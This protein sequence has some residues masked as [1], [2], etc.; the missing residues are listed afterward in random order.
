MPFHVPRLPADARPPIGW[1]PAPFS[2]AHLKAIAAFLLVPYVL[3]G[4]LLPR[5]FSPFRLPEG[6]ASPSW[7]LARPLPLLVVLAAGNAY[8]GQ[9]V[10]RRKFMFMDRYGGYE[11]FWKLMASGLLLVN[12]GVG[13]PPPKPSTTLFSFAPSPNFLFYL[14]FIVGLQ[15]AFGDSIPLLQ[16]FGCKWSI[17]SR[18]PSCT[19]A[20]RIVAVLLVGGVGGAVALVATRLLDAPRV[21]LEILA[22]V[23]GLAFAAIAAFVYTRR[24]MHYSFHLHHY[25]CVLLLLPLTGSWDYSEAD[26]AKASSLAAAFLDGLLLGIYVDGVTVWG[27][28]PLLVPRTLRDIPNVGETDLATLTWLHLT[29]IV[30]SPVKWMQ[31]LRRLEPIYEAVIR[32]LGKLPRPS[33]FEFGILPAMH[34]DTQYADVARRMRMDANLLA[35]YMEIDTDRMKIACGV[36]AGV[37]KK[38]LGP[39]RLMARVRGSPADRPFA[40]DVTLSVCTAYMDTLFRFLMF[41]GRE[42]RQLARLHLRWGS[43]AMCEARRAFAAAGLGGHRSTGVAQSIFRHFAPENTFGNGMMKDNSDEDFEKVL[44]H[45]ST[46]ILN[47]ESWIF[48]PPAMNLNGNEILYQRMRFNITDGLLDLFR[49]AE[50]GKLGDEGTD[51]V[52][53]IKLSAAAADDC[54]DDEV[55]KDLLQLYASFKRE[56]TAFSR[57]EL[58][59]DYGGGAFDVDDVGV[60]DDAGEGEGEEEDDDDDDDDDDGPRAGR[61]PRRRNEAERIIRDIFGPQQQRGGAR[62]GWAAGGVGGRAQAPRHRVRAR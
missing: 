35:K 62:R 42:L 45:H 41:G 18:W 46:R 25:F 52:E 39:A 60:D 32:S 27:M 21:F 19:S 5:I 9:A 44:L 7:W 30:P 2:L 22:L 3:F 57:R 20:E 36:P 51:G 13:P 48:R 40:A 14:G 12:A 55:G 15:F 37:A 58:Y 29:P 61:G 54:D 34:F 38:I 11:E 53:D 24:A 59:G 47:Y 4:L 28:D 26:E 31:L 50:E 1:P 49:L 56:E 33:R 6:Q 16:G 43:D 23:Y 8:T 17:P 10:V